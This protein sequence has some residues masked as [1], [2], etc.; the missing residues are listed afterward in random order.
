VSINSERRK[1]K[2]YGIKGGGPGQAGANFIRKNNGKLIKL[3][4]RAVLRTQRN[5]SIIIETPGGGGYGV[6]DKFQ[7]PNIK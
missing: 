4:H 1:N 3:K 7:N 2:P 6:K 5:E